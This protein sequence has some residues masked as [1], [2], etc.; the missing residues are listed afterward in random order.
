MYNR[1]VIDADHLP[2]SR[3]GL[4]WLVRL[5]WLAVIGQLAATVVATHVHGGQVSHATVAVEVETSRR[6][7]LTVA[8]DRRS[9]N[10]G[11]TA[12]VIVRARTTDGAPRDAVVSLW[13]ADAPGSRAYLEATVTLV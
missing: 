6:F 10:A 11:S 3:P 2:D 7:G 5:R 13:V 9:Y 8:T 4:A 12:R 1:P